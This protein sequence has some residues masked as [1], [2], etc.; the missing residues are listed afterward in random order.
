MNYKKGKDYLANGL[1]KK[2]YTSTELA[3]KLSTTGAYIRTLVD[4]GLPYIEISR[5]DFR[6]DI[7]EVNDWLDE[8]HYSNE[9]N[10]YLTGKEMM[11]Y[12]AFGD[13]TLRRFRE[14]GMPFIPAE[15]GNCIK[16]NP[17]IVQAWISTHYSKRRLV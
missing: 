4:K 10:T 1:I 15:N 14:E 9:R 11:Q 17:E 6:F 12:Y 2:F 7:E 16:Y 3:D 5:T 13:V 8:N